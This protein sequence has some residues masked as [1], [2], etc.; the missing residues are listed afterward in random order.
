MAVHATWHWTRHRTD[1]QIRSILVHSLRSFSACSQA[2]HLTRRWSR[3]QRL[4][5]ECSGRRRHL[6]DATID[7]ARSLR[8]RAT[9]AHGRRRASAPRPLFVALVHCGPITFVP[10]EDEDV[11][12]E[13]LA[14]IASQFA[15]CQYPLTG[16]CPRPPAFAAFFSAAAIFLFGCKTLGEYI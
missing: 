15:M 13:L 16:Q 9:S 8:T 4:A 14:A 2:L 3:Q 1:K 7:G 5:L 10:R 12:Y 11:A 6:K